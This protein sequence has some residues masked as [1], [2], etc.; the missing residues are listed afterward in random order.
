MKSIAIL[1]GGILFLQ[2]CTLVTIGVSG[3]SSIY[4]RIEKHRIEKRLE[5]LERKN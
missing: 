2:G 5:E 4:D 3:V 1:I